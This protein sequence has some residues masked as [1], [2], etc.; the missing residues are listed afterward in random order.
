ML[1]CV[2]PSEGDGLQWSAIESL[3]SNSLKIPNMTMDF[4]K[5][6]SMIVQHNH[7]EMNNNY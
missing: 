5:F 6:K 4:I 1:Y 3:F 7:S 2:L